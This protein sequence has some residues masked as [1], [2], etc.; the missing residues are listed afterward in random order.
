M[1]Q[2]NQATVELK[3]KTNIKTDIVGWIKYFTLLIAAYI[4]LTNIVGLTWI[5]GHSMDPTLKD[6]SLVLINKA[7]VHLGH[8]EHGDVV[9][10]RESGNRFTII[11]RVI[12]LPGDRVAIKDGT[13][14]VNDIPQVE[15]YTFGKAKDM[16][17]VTV[18]PN[19]L[20]IVGD[21]RTPGQSLDS[22][23]PKV[24]TVPVSSVEGYAVISLYPM[25]RIMKPLE[26]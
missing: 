12:G 13:V 8:P 23:S 26:F 9:T 14:Y 3:G 2:A 15:I 20:F 21:N 11:K 17:E 18:E 5:S 24:G 6:G 22:R 10:V 1:N 7:S 16:K 19:R 4:F 25:Y